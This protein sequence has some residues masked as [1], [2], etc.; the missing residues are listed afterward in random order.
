MW[1]WPCLLFPVLLSTRS[2][3]TGRFRIQTARRHLNMQKIQNALLAMNEASFVRFSSRFKPMPD[4]RMQR[5]LTHVLRRSV[6]SSL[7]SR[8]LNVSQRQLFYSVVKQ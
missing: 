8:W 1:L 6:E 4:K 7:V 3:E 2:I 5:D